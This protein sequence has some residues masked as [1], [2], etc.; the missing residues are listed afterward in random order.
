MIIRIVQM[1]FRADAIDEFKALFDEVSPVIRTFPG[2]RHLE[3]WQDQDE[4]GRIFT[5][6]HW[7]A[8]NDLEH[9]RG[10]DFFKETWTRTKVLFHSRANAWTVQQIA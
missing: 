3:L 8:P 1:H 7:D 10:S 2:C 4:P 6:S 5:Y 9:Y